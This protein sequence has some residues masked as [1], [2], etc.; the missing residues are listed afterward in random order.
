[1]S[2]IPESHKD[3]LENKGFAHLAS[4][5]PDGEPQSHPVWFAWD[6][7][8]IQVSTTKDRQKYRNVTNDSRVSVSILDPENPY[9]YLELRGQVTKVDDDADYSFINSLAKKY[10]DKDEY[11]FHQPGD[12]RVIIH[13]A[14]EHSATMG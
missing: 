3:I 12:E 11:P 14:P 10:M 7:S 13:I 2:A 1:M 4:L 8:T 6:G 5:G 9:R